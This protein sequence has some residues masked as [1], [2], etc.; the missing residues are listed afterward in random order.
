MSLRAAL[1]GL[2]LFSLQ[3]AAEQRVVSLAPFLTD[4][5]VQ[6]EATE[7]LVGVFDD[8]S[9]PASLEALPRVGGYH[10][11]A[12]E[13]IIAQRPDLVLAWTSGNPPGLL[14]RLE[15]LGIEVHRY[16][17]QRLEDIE[18]TLLDV[19][20]LVGADARA[21]ELAGDYRAALANVGRPLNTASPS[22]FVQVWDDPL[23]T[24]SDTQLVGD[25]L[26]H[27]G[28]RNV[29]G[30]LR[31]LAPQVGRENVIAANP[32][33]IL[34]LA[35]ERGQATG[36]LNRWRRFPQIAAVR[37]RRLYILDSQQLARATPGII[38]GVVRLCQLVA[39]DPERAAEPRE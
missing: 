20:R 3:T 32:D 10:D 39:S 11:L 8:P 16:D 13:P 5:L 31:L 12:L 29:F 18:Q 15:R 19:G 26:R 14:A 25:A 34:I 17:P 4:L 24:L 1:L 23:Y 7:Q 22:V 9:L 33:I 28:A 6:L 35:D 21:A 2:A 38:D 37:D 27:C 30:D 36:W